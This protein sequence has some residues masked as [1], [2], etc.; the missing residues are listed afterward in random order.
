MNK[1]IKA[2]VIVF[3]GWVTLHLIAFILAKSYTFNK[4]RHNEEFWP[5]VDFYKR[6]LSAWTEES[7][8]WTQEA[9]NGIFYQYNLPELIAYILISAFFLFAYVMK[10][11]DGKQGDVKVNNDI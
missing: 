8:T 5:F 11:Y 10:H 4:S 2:A 9:F 1:K 7:I 3:T 6:R